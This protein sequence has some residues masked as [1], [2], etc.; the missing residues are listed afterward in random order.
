[1]AA[2]GHY[3][4]HVYWGFR[5]KG[6]V[7]ISHLFARRWLHG[8]SGEAELTY[9]PENTSQREGQQAGGETAAFP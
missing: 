4:S 2:S 6:L 3:N 5:D 9:R 1:M 7:L 8:Y